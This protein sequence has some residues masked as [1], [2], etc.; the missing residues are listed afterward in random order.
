MAVT[1]T[2]M[3]R[4]APGHLPSTVPSREP[5]AASLSRAP[6]AGRIRA[7]PKSGLCLTLREQIPLAVELRRAFGGFADLRF[8]AQDQLVIAQFCDRLLPRALGWH[9][10]LTYGCG[11][12]RHRPLAREQQPRLRLIAGCALEGVMKI[13]GH[14]QLPIVRHADQA[15]LAPARQASHGTHPTPRLHCHRAPTIAARQA[16]HAIFQRVWPRRCSRHRRVGKGVL[17]HAV[18]TRPS[19]FAK[20]ARQFASVAAPIQGQ[21][22]PPDI[23]VKTAVRPIAYARHMAVLDRIEMDIIDVPL[24]VSLVANRMLPIATLPNPPLPVGNFARGDW[25]PAW[26]PPRKPRLDHIPAQ[27][28]ITVVRRERPDC[29]QMIGQHANG[30]RL[31]WISLLNRCIDGS[32]P[33]DMAH[34]HVARSVGQSDGEEKTATFDV[35]TTISWQSLAY[36]FR[37][38][39]KRTRGHGVQ[40]TPLPTLHS[41]EHRH[42]MNP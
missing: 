33:I 16:H 1:S 10:C 22:S 3:T 13:A 34:E 9:L 15:H 14:Q 23:P 41:S 18:P 8:G 26:K 2:A 27:R 20:R 11:C 17:L 25:H 35:C 24:Q 28:E 4:L 29:M 12:N 5:A 40:S 21:H 42:K 30:D 7:R 38:S 39:A 32:E 37:L 6:I 19:L 36:R 31:E